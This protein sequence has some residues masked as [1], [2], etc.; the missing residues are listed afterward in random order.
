MISELKPEIMVRDRWI[1]DHVAELLHGYN[2]K[3]DFGRLVKECGAALPFAMGAEL[4]ERV[5][6]IV[7]IETEIRCRI[8]RDERS[9]FWAGGKLLPIADTIALM[10]RGWLPWRGYIPALTIE[11]Y[12]IVSRR[13]VTDTGVASFVDALQGT[14]T[15]SN[16]K[17]HGFGTSSTAEAQTQ[18]ALVAEL[19]TQYA[20]DNVRPTGTQAETAATVYQTVGTLSPDVT[21][22][23]EEHAP[24]N[25]A[26]NAG[27]VML[28]RS[29][30]GTKALT[31]S[32][33]SLQ[34]DYRMTIAAGG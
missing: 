33:D 7:V 8:Y 4:L 10:N 5:A 25:Q 22:T 9:D 1:P 30:T 28:D 3:T 2:P 32:L 13:L 31:A 14:F 29:L 23:I 11:D 24:F 19:T 18:S 20:T 12:G 26:S 21:V 34:V 17:F 27:G 6:S 16:Y 15:I